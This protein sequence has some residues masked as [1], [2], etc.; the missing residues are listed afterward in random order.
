MQATVTKKTYR[1]S[2]DCVVDQKGHLWQACDVQ[3]DTSEEIELVLD[4]S[5]YERR[6]FCYSVGQEWTVYNIRGTEVPI[7]DT[8]ILEYLNEI[9]QAIPG[10][11]T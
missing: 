5:P 3:Q 8:N 9:R 11:R 4:T 10:N 7:T 2:V 6:L 1:L